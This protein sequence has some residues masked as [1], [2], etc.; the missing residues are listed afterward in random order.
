MAMASCAAIEMGRFGGNEPAAARVFQ[1]T[2]MPCEP[3]IR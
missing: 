2:L 1:L 3:A